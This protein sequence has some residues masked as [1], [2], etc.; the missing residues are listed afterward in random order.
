MIV[1]APLKAIAVRFFLLIYVKYTEGVSHQ[2]RRKK[3]LVIDQ[4]PVTNNQ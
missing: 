2:Y 1:Y 4:S 3:R